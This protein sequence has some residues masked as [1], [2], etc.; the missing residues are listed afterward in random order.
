M[1][2]QPRR[3]TPI[4]MD[5]SVPSILTAIKENNVEFEDVTATIN[6]TVAAANEAVYEFDG[7]KRSGNAFK[8][9]AKIPE[10]IQR[11]IQWLSNVATILRIYFQVRVEDFVGKLGEK[12]RMRVTKLI[13]SFQSSYN[14]SN[15]VI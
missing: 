4:D 7:E 5:L 13:I 12:E 14:A 9:H 11:F 3:N 6:D 8:R 15:S 1:C 10:P 2:P